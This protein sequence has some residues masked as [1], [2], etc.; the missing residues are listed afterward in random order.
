MTAF[1]KVQK[2]LRACVKTDCL[3]C[4][5]K[6]TGNGC[7]GKLIK[8]ANFIID[9]AGDFVAICN[10]EIHTAIKLGDNEKN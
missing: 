8:D 7:I 5:Y 2:G 6:Q 3:K 10:Q 4:P 9:Y 1:N